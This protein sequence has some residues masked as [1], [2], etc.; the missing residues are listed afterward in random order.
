MMKHMLC[1][2]DLMR[3]AQIVVLLSTIGLSACGAT[4]PPEMSDG[5]IALEEGIPEVVPEPVMQ[6]P[7]LPKPEQR[8]SLETYTVIVNQVPVRDL[9]FSMARDAKLNL[10]IDNNISG[11]VTMNAIDQTLP[12]I[13]ERLSRQVS[14]RY[15]LEDE[16][17]H[18][19]ADKPYL[20]LYDINY[21][22][23]SR[24]STGSVEVSTEITSTGG[25]IDA[26]GGGKSKSGGNNS[27]SVV[28]NSSDNE[29]WKTLVSNIANVIGDNDE[30]NKGKDINDNKNILVN[31]ETGVIGVRATYAQH[32]QVQ[33][34]LDKVLNS[35]QRQ[36]LIE[37]TIAEVTLS[38]TYQAG[39]DWSIV[40]ATDPL[41]NITRGADQNLLGGN[42]GNAP[43]F[44]IS[45][46]GSN[47]GRP[48]SATLKALET[49]GDVKVLSSPKVM[50]LNNQNAMLKVVDNE[51]Y[52]SIEVTPEKV[53]AT[54]GLVTSPATIDTDINTVPIGFVMS[55]MPYIDKNDVVTLHVRPTI[56]RIVDT[57]DD[58]NPELA[59]EGVVS[60]I[61]VIQVREIESVLNVESGNTA[62]IGGLMQDTIRKTNSGVPILSSIPLLGALFSYQ[63]DEYVKSELVIFIRPVV[64]HDAS[65]IGDLSD[66][67]QYLHDD[68]DAGTSQ[69]NTSQ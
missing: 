48:V 15:R 26:G 45:A 67:R 54:T 32:R 23:M 9:L 24:N 29:F 36:V 44:Q 38:D 40:S 59:K 10:D 65:L 46:I 61:P 51:V 31:R 1:R 33:E 16:T 62:I 34:L 7:V 5:H 25:S 49:F 39:I 63:E 56:S 53:N 55:V 4:N 60:Q 13:L 57:A 14:L 3:T 66:Y 2:L 17:L 42:L 21:L 43:F 50:A 28:K 52:F 64:I 47:G 27:S 6:A 11:S 12:Q 30:K 19:S 8:P 35:A 18:V 69:S 20:Q 37:A 58:P 68:V 22:N 41:N